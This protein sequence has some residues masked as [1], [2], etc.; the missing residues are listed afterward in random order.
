VLAMTERSKKPQDG[1]GAART[2]GPQRQRRAGAKKTRAARSREASPSIG[3]ADCEG[4]TKRLRK[5]YDGESP[6]PSWRRYFQAY[7]TL[8]DEGNPVTETAIA[9]VLGISRMSLWRVHRRNPGLRRWVHEQ[10]RDSN[11]FLIGPVVRM[12]G[13]TAVRTKSPKHAELFLKA[14]GAIGAREDGEGGDRPTLNTGNA[15]FNF[16]VPA[17]PIPA[18]AQEKAKQMLPP[19]MTFDAVSAP[20][21]P[22]HKLTVPA[23]VPVVTTR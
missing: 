6:R 23:N 1:A 20:P 15:V 2:H 17:P 5:P 3:A 21:P 7:V 8:L 9:K 11:E 19:P 14:V 13:T 12:L 4:V 22:A 18:L 16:L 10:L